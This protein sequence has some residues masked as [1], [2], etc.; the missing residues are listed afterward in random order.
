MLLQRAVGSI[1]DPAQLIV[2]TARALKEMANFR[3]EARQ[4]HR[5][6]KNVPLEDFKDS[7]AYQSLVK[8][9]E[10]RFDNVYS[11]KVDFGRATGTKPSG[12]KSKV[13]NSAIIKNGEAIAERYRVKPQ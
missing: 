5:S 10:A 9:Y 4:I 2:R 8:K 11:Q 7:A 3:D 12:S 13:D 1:S 6:M